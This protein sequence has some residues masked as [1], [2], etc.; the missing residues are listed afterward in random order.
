MSSVTEVARTAKQPYGG[1]IK[2]SQFKEVNLDD[3]KELVYPENLS[4]AT[5]GMIVD[6]MTRYIM[7]AKLTEAFKIS[8]VGAVYARYLGRPNA[9]ND[10]K[11]IL[12]EIKG[13]DDRSIISACKMVWFDAYY[14]VPMWAKD[15]ESDA[16]KEPDNQ[17]IAN[18]R[19][20]INRSVEFWKQYGPIEK[21][22]F[23]FEPVEE[24]YNGKNE[25]IS[26]CGDYG[27]YTPTVNAGDGDYLTKD[28]L[29][30]FKVSQ[31]KLSSK[32]TLQLLMYWIMGC[33]SGKPEFQTIKKLGIYNPR[34]NVVYLLNVEDISDETIKTVEKDVIGYGRPASQKTSLMKNF[35]ESQSPNQK[36]KTQSV[37]YEPG[38]IVEHKVFGRG[39]VLKVKPAAGDQIVEI[40]FE[41]VG[42]KKTMAN[43]APL[44]KITTEE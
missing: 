26:G 23:T 43:F 11:Q 14:R 32:I 28:T 37:S 2:P 1:F 6:Y 36:K 25:D 22:G 33:H 24:A 35:L 21:D 38:D 18:I 27:G 7:G 44:V 17:T 10:A 8:C 41:K 9:V 13:L 5:V 31:R 12:K 30:D 40:S 20:M 4:P 3:G 29:W 16:K 39:K 42:V 34:L 19:T 15:H